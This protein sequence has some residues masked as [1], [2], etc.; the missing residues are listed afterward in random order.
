ME[1]ARTKRFELIDLESALRVTNAVTKVYGEMTVTEA[2]IRLQ[3]YKAEIAWLRSLQ[4]RAHDKTVEQA[5]EYGDEMK[6]VQVDREFTC[7]LPEAK[8]AALIANVQTA[9]DDLNDRV[10]SANHRTMLVAK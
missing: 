3:E 5:V 9:F 2:T 8:R 1:Q 10:E 7:A 6:M 4:V